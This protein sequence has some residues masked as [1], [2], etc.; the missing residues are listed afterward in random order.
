MDGHLPLKKNGRH[1]IN[2]LQS[3]EEA[4]LATTVFK[5]NSILRCVFTNHHPES[6]GRQ[7]L[8]AGVEGGSAES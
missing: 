8:C 7:Q 5:V 2:I 3:L 6:P 4:L 1:S